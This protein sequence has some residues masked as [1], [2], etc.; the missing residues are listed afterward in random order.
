MKLQFRAAAFAALVLATWPS[1]AAAHDF[2]LLPDQFHGAG[3]FGVHATVSAAFPAPETVVGQDRI[4]ELRASEG[5]SI[6]VS[7]PGSHSLRLTLTPSRPGA[8]VAGVRLLPREVEYEGE[9]I[10]LI[11]EEYDVSAEARQ[12]VAALAVP[13]VL[14]ASSERFAKTIVC[15]ETCAG[16][17]AAQAFGYPL[18]FVADAAGAGR[19]RLLLN[20]HPLPDY[21]VAIATSGGRASGRTD[22]EGRVT[23][24]LDSDGPSMIFA[25]HM[26]P[27]AE[28]GGHFIMLLTSLTI[29][30]AGSSR[31]GSH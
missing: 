15:S 7:G 30:T 18:E 4:A 31:D 28:A 19:F 23:A 14:R 3:S 12:A 8:H 20:G 17:A 6:A 21:P 16:A 5:A 26:H 10:A 27:P 11:M 13:Q 25:A 9:R 24:N 22:A 2:F 1:A 29:P